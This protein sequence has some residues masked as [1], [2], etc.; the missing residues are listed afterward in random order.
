MVKKLKAVMLL[1]SSFTFRSTHKLEAHRVAT[2]LTL[3]R[4]C[5]KQSK[6]L[7]VGANHFNAG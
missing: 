3:A 4:A 1:K 6:E 5:Q 2:M 7:F